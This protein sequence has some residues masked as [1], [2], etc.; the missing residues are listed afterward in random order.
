MSAV[1]NTPKN[2]AATYQI[3]IT[4]FKHVPNA[5]PTLS[6]QTR[7]LSY[8]V[9]MNTLVWATTWPIFSKTFCLKICLVGLFIDQ[10]EV[11]LKTKA[12]FG[13][14]FAL[15]IVDIH[16]RGISIIV[17][18]HVNL[19]PFSICWPIWRSQQNWLGFCLWDPNWVYWM[20]WV[21]WEA[22]IL[23]IRDLPYLKLDTLNTV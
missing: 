22:H 9:S 15:T 5:F 3:R 23:V 18:Q 11:F 7:N 1:L 16:C 20:Y 4:P 6:Y 17:I 21:Y 14:E 8:L 2:L 10:K 13:L 19:V 12:N